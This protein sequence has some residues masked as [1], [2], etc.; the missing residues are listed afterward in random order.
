M[1]E[2]PQPLKKEIFGYVTK[3]GSILSEKEQQER[4][5]AFLKDKEETD[6]LLEVRYDLGYIEEV[7]LYAIFWLD[8][9]LDATIGIWVRTGQGKNP[10]TSY[11]DLGINGLRFRPWYYVE[12]ENG[13]EGRTI[14]RHWQAKTG[15]IRT[16]V[17]FHD[18]D[19]SFAN[20]LVSHLM[21]RVAQRSWRC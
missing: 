6:R 12:V 7:Q 9:T 16:Q 10:L 8:E 13:K 4:A 2:D 19:A 5:Q 3:V 15:G 1:V 21:K 17:V 20:W 18:L 11:V 14:R